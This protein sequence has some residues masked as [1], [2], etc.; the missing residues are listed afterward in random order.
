MTASTRPVSRRGWAAPAAGPYCTTVE[1]L[2]ADVRDASL[3]HDLEVVRQL[4][5][6][7]LRWATMSWRRDMGSGSQ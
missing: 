1:H 6:D 5:L 3:P 7:Y 4:W 2:M